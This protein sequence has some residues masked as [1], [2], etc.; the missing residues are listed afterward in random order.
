MHSFIFTCF[1][2]ISPKNFTCNSYN[3]YYSCAM[4]STCLVF[5]FVSCSFVHGTC[6]EC[7][8][9]LLATNITPIDIMALERNRQFIGIA[10]RELILFFFFFIPKKNNIFCSLS[11][12]ILILS[13][14]LLLIF[15]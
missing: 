2:F 11:S 5:Y 9:I 7:Y 4:E 3:G 1:S 8:K 6:E 14:H 10:L 13:S 12:A 15:S